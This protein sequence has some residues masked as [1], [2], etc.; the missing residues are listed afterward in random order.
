MIRKLEDYPSKSRESETISKALRK[1]G[2]S[3]VGPTI[4][5]AHMQAT[6]IVN[7]HTID[8]YRRHEI[9]AMTTE[10]ILG[11]GEKKPSRGE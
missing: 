9:M 10:S 4:V 2:F 1:R 7:D 8:C 6:G 3:F 11:E 5:Y